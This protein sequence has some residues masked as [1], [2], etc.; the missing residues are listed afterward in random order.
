MHYLFTIAGQAPAILC[1]YDVVVLF[2]AR[3][4]PR[5]C[6]SWIVPRP[7]SVSGNETNATYV[8]V[9]KT[10]SATLRIVGGPASS[11]L[12]CLC[13][14]YVTSKLG[15]YTVAWRPAATMNRKCIVLVR[16][17]TSWGR[18]WAS[19]WHADIEHVAICKDMHWWACHREVMVDG[20]CISHQWPH[21]ARKQ[22]PESC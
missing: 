6:D 2:A 3:S 15:L 18:A 1:R 9:S 19:R 17:T 5:N 8:C 14:Q 7:N 12:L 16:C 13:L 20:S 22:V 4:T 11:P 21:P 10:V